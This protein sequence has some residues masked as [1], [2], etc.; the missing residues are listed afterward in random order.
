[1]A[2]DFIRRCLQYHKEDRASVHELSNH[3]LFKF[4]IRSGKAFGNL[5]ASPAARSAKAESTEADAP[6]PPPQ[7]P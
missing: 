7:Q 1:M 3:D 4:G 5:P 6:P 2:Q